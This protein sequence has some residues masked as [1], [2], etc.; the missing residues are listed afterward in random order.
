MP[1]YTTPES[2][3]HSTHGQTAGKCRKHHLP[4]RHTGEEQNSRAD[5]YAQCRSLAKRSGDKTD[6]R[7]I[8]VG[9]NIRHLLLRGGRRDL[10]QRSS[11][12]ETVDSLAA[13]SEHGFGGHKHTV[14]A[15]LPRIGE[16]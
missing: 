10:A 15:H 5:E 1:K 7:I 16:K 9:R 6:K 14:T 13:E 12:G 2:V 11:A 8:P 3:H 4:A